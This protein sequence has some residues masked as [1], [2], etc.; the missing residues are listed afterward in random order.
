MCCHIR[1]SCSVP[2]LQ[3]DIFLFPRLIHRNRRLNFICSRHGDL[4]PHTLKHALY[5]LLYYIFTLRITFHTN[6]SHSRASFYKGICNCDNPSRRQVPRLVTFPRSL[7]A[8]T[9][10][11]TPS[12]VTP[13]FLYRSSSFNR[14]IHPWCTADAH[15]YPI[16][17]QFLQQ[18]LLLQRPPASA[19]T[20]SSPIPSFPLKLKLS[21]AGNPS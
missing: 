4:P 17:V 7:I 6:I 8:P 9:T 15:P 5:Y 11:R 16:Q 10:A 18:G 21:N 2:R 12:S 13:L 14:S 19:T 1:F 3:Y 20:P